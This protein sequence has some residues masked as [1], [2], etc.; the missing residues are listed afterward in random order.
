M[1][2]CVN[3]GCSLR[4]GVLTLPWKTEIILMHMLPACIV[5]RKTYKKDTARMTIERRI[6]HVDRSFK[7]R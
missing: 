3:C 7:E 2:T 5:E 4:G 1:D 6:G